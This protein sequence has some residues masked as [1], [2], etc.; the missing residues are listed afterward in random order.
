MEFYLVL[1][2]SAI[3]G[4]SI[5]LSL[6]FILGNR[7]GEKTSKALVSVAIGILIFLLAD[8]FSDASGMLYNGTLGG[9]GSSPYYDA[10]FTISLIAG[11]F[12]LFAFEFRSGKELKPLHISLMIAVGIGLQNLTEGLVFGADAHVIGLTG[13]ALVIFVGFIIQNITEGF[14]IGAPFISDSRGNGKALFLLFLIGG[15]PTILG[16]GVGFYFNSIPF[17]LAFDGLA[18]GAILYIL[19]PMLRSILPG[20]TRSIRSLIYSGIFL[21]FLVGLMVNLI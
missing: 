18:I 5:Y 3:I 2:F 13:V 9:Y 6:P 14:P 21:G 8:V 20:Q 1:F 15:F 7:Y 19:L 4:L 12:M 11:F 10:I 17:D 16:G